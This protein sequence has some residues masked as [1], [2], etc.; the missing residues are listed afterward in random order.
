MNWSDFLNFFCC[1]RRLRFNSQRYPFVNN[2]S[3]NYSVFYNQ[4]PNNLYGDS[5]LHTIFTKPSSEN[6]EWQYVASKY[7]N[8][9]Q[10]FEPVVHHD[11]D[12]HPYIVAKYAMGPV[13]ST[14]YQ[15]PEDVDHPYIVAKYALGPVESTP[16]Q[17][18]EDVDHPY[19]VAKYA[20]G[21]IRA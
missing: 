4:K 5:P 17:P 18:P 12:Y 14:P 13:E 19:I 16:Y 1:T 9:P 3:Y 11:D 2:N 15:P 8:G 10:F 6:V 7:A 20:M 21:P